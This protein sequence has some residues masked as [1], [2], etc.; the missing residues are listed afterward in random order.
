MP[1]DI[2]PVTEEEK[3]IWPKTVIVPLELPFTDERAGI[4]PLVDMDMKSCVL[5]SSKAGS[6]RANHYHKTDWRFCYILKGSIDYYHR[7]TG[8][9]AEPEP[10]HVRAGQLFTPPM[11]DH[12][13]VFPENTEFFTLGRNSRAQDVDEADVVRVPVKTNPQCLKNAL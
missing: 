1:A 8:A 13:M 9:A 10:V 4:Q 5:I 3:I 6:V 7:P 11:A 12:A 2:K